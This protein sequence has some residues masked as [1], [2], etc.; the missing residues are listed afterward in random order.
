MLEFKLVSSNSQNGNCYYIEYKE[1]K[2]LL[3]DCGVTYKKLSTELGKKRIAKIDTIYVS[4]LHGDHWNKTTIKQLINNS[5]VDG[6][7]IIACEEL[8][9]SIIDSLASMQ[10]SLYGSFRLCDEN[11]D[12]DIGLIEMNHF[13]SIRSGGSGKDYC[14]CYGADIL[15]PETKSRV[16]FITDTGYYEPS[17]EVLDREY[18]LVLLECNYDDRLL[19]ANNDLPYILKERIKRSHL[20]LEQHNKIKG[21]LTYKEL[22]PIHKSKSNL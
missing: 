21:M 15:I 10:E 8:I 7:N 19:K 18:D 12:I 22:I 17:K 1:G 9:D 5:D 20:S 4:H 16:L 11:L 14:L 3:L 2:A 13:N 6:I